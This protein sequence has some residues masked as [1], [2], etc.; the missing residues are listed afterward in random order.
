MS[1]PL[2]K[3]DSAVG[4]LSSSPPKASANAKPSKRAS[5]SVPGV[6][7]VEQLY[8]TKTKLNVAPETL[9]TGW[10]I[11]TSPTTI[12]EKEIL[13]KLLINPPVKRIDIHFPLGMVVTAR[14]NSGVTIKDALDAIHKP[15]K[16]KADDE[17]DNGYLAGFIWDGEHPD[18][19]NE[20]ERKTEWTRLQILLQSTP[21]A[22]NT[23]G[24][25]KKK[26]KDKSEE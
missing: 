22:T 19:K 14:K 20:E 13:N 10:K 6:Y 23:G 16:K 3:V 9:K 21:G 7:T 1:E 5:S 4:G 26:N 18:L 17:L 24:G 12:E 2:S 15:Y 11:N 25:K 8:E